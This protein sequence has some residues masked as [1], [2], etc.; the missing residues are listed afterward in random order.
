MLCKAGK[1]IVIQVGPY[2]ASIENYEWSCKDKKFKEILDFYLEEDGPS[3]SDPYP[4]LTA[5]NTII[6]KLGGE[7]IR[8]DKKEEVDE[9]GLIY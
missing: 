5:A 9:K 4:D 8:Q 1:M 2:R 7:I 3:P 6:N